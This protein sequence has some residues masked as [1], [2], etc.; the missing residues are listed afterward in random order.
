[1]GKGGALICIDKDS[2][3]ERVSAEISQGHFSSF[4][5]RISMPHSPQTPLR[6]W[7]QVP[8]NIPEALL[9]RIAS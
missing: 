1:M 6:I 5:S 4:P 8:G 2:L 9:S 7:T 3:A